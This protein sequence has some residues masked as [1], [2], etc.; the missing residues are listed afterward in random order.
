MLS[1]KAPA[2]DATP[3]KVRIGNK[4]LSYGDAMPFLLKQLDGTNEQKSRAAVALQAYGDTLVDTPAFKRLLAIFDEK[5]DFSAIDAK[6]KVYSEKNHP[7]QDLSPKEKLL[8]ERSD[9]KFEALLALVMSGSKEG[10]E[11]LE[12]MRGSNSE[13]ERWIAKSV[14]NVHDAQGSWKRGKVPT[15][16]AVAQ[17]WLGGKRL[18]QPEFVKQVSEAFASGDE[19][20]ILDALQTLKGDGYIGILNSPDGAKVM[21]NALESSHDLAKRNHEIRAARAESARAAFFYI[22]SLP[23]E[24]SEALLPYVEA[25]AKDSDPDIAEHAWKLL[26]Y[27]RSQH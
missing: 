11:R 21:M 10:A 16:P 4:W 17:Y 23:R 26:Q 27:L 20:Q 7:P 18:K 5:I 13:T 6:I 14:K 8:A 9:V 22:E 3:E 25:A 24:K 19:K 12:K 15:K 2:Q 1:C